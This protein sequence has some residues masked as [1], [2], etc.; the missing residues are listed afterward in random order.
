MPFPFFWLGALVAAAF[1]TIV[2]TIFGLLLK[3]MDRAAT[4]VR[5]SVLPGLV[6]GIRDWADGRGLPR[7]ASSSPRAAESGSGLE[8]T[9]TNAGLRL[10]HVRRAR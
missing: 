9:P 1:L 5:E 3:M 10:E 7:V 8:E 2:M 6:T 4:E